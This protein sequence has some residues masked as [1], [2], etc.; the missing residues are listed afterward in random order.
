ML[1]NIIPSKVRRKILELYFHHIDDSYYLREIVRLIDEEVNAVKRELDILHDA[2]V[3]IRERRTNKV[4]YTV[5]KN[6]I[7]YDEFLRIFTKSTS[8]ADLLLKNNSRLGKVKFIALSTKYVKRTPIKEDEIYALF[9]GVIVVP[10]VESI[11]NS[12]KK[13]FGW[14]INFTVMTVDEFQFRKKNNDPF[15]WKFLKQP[16]VMLVGQE[17]DLV[18]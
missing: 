2:K 10:E 16:K 14:E 6:Y 5:N 11:M 3:L 12:A 1:E 17:E 13:E 8:L 15:I 4:F 9:V 7:L 18:K